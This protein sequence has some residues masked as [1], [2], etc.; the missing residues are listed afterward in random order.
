MLFKKEFRG[1]RSGEIYPTSFRPGDECPA[2]LRVAAVEV[3]ALES[4]EEAKARTAAE[5]KGEKAAQKR[6]DILLA[7]AKEKNVAIGDDATE[8]QLVEALAAAGVE[9][10]QA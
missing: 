3:G 6:V 4:A 9:I 1:C 7:L 2:E 10:P 8:E 5:R